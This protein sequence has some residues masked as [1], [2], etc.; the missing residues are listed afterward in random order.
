MI[1]GLWTWLED[2]LRVV[3]GL[4]AAYAAAIGV[5]DALSQNGDGIVHHCTF[6]FPS[7]ISSADRASLICCVLILRS[8]RIQRIAAH[9]EMPSTVLVFLVATGGRVSVVATCKVSLIACS[10][11]LPPRFFHPW[12][13]DARRRWVKSRG[14]RF[15]LPDHVFRLKKSVF[16]GAFVSA[17]NRVAMLAL[18]VFVTRPLPPPWSFRLR[19]FASGGV[20]PQ[21]RSALDVPIH[22]IWG[23]PR[24]GLSSPS[25]SRFVVMTSSTTTAAVVKDLARKQPETFVV[26]KWLSCLH[27]QS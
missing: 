10:P 3:E 14:G 5:G 15:A 16:A 17:R 12:A 11:S 9:P 21:F 22:P 27:L 6:L 24:S 8:D 4:T 23:V 1:P 19:F 25:Y 26:V 2:V 18:L 20:S 7:G 13:W